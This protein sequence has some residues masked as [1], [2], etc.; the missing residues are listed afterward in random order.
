M[1]TLYPY[2]YGPVGTVFPIRAAVAQKIGTPS[3]NIENIAF[4]MHIY[5]K[6]SLS[7]DY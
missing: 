6:E 4:F 1:S 2:I 3:K 7:H 5:I